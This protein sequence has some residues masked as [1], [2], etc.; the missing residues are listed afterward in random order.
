MLRLPASTVVVPTL[1]TDRLIL[2]PPRPEDFEDS[3]ALWS[4]PDVVRFIGGRVFTREE[5]W[6][7]VLRYI[8][9][10][11]ALGWGY[12]MVRDRA[13]GRYLGEAGFA[14]AEREM[15]PSIVG[16]PEAGWALLPSAHGRGLAGEAVAAMT[17]WAD[18]NFGGAPTVCI[19]APE[20][21]PSIRVAEKAGYRP[22]VL[23][24]YRGSPTQVFERTAQ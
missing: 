4:D 20:N 24:T 10:W 16:Q 3:F 9:H 23:A 8:G 18:A 12:W 19:I 13:D 22:S 2:A 7:R 15:T 11:A 17:A 21:T 1:T 5:V 6:G 14:E